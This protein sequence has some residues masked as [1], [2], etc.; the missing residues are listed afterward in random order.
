MLAAPG[1]DILAD[2]VRAAEALRRLGDP[3]AAALTIAEALLDQ[4]ALAGI[5]NVYK[6]EALFLERVDPFARV[7]TSTT[8]PSNAWSRPR[9]G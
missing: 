5:G 6:N 3:R 7:A 9:G 4:R 8:R 2:D 1:P